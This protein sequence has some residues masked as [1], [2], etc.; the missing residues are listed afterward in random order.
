M[1]SMV[2]IKTVKIGIARKPTFAPH[3]ALTFKVRK[4]LARNAPR[5]AHPA[6]ID[7]VISGDTLLMAKYIAIPR[8]A[9]KKTEKN[10]HAFRPI[11]IP[12]VIPSARRIVI[13]VAT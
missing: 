5:N 9:Q 6:V 4:T 8:I 7:V 2:D 11:D 13:I 3:L 10:S 12:S 1:Y